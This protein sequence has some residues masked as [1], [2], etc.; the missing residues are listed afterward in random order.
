MHKGCEIGETVKASYC[1]RVETVKAHVHVRT[2]QKRLP[3]DWKAGIHREQVCP[4][5]YQYWDALRSANYVLPKV[6]AILE[7]KNSYC[8]AIGAARTT[9]ADY[10]GVNRA[11]KN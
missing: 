5:T 4:Y 3:T 9:S 2:L 6:N 7:T 10:S 11:T 1:T 8:L